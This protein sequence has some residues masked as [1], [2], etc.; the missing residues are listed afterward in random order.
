MVMLEAMRAGVPLVASAIG[1]IRETLDGLPGIVPPR[2]EEAM[3]EAVAAFLRHPGLRAE[4]SAR[5]KQLFVER[6]S[7]DKTVDRVLRVYSRCAA[8]GT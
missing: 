6:F 2:E 7:I 8:E 5:L 1:G 3:A 4:C